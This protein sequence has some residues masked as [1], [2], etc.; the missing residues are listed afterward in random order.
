MCGGTYHK[1]D[2]KVY[3]PYSRWCHGDVEELEYGW[4]I[5]SMFQN[6]GR[7]ERSQRALLEYFELTYAPW[8][9]NGSVIQE[10]KRIT[11]ELGEQLYKVEEILFW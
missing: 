3:D 1:D 10:T 7:L 6:F 8:Q 9:G 11:I 5:H 2:G 4:M